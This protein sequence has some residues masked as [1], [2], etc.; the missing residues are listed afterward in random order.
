MRLPKVTTRWQQA[1]KETPFPFNRLP[2]ELKLLI[3]E[4]CG[5]DFF[6][7]DTSRLTV[8]RQW[9]QLALPV[10][11]YEMILTKCRFPWVWTPDHSALENSVIPLYHDPAFVPVAVDRIDKYTKV[12]TINIDQL[13]HRWA[14]QVGDGEFTGTTLAHRLAHL[15][16]SKPFEVAPFT[17]E[18]ATLHALDTLSLLRRG[19]IKVKDLAISMRLSWGVHRQYMAHLRSVMKTVITTPIE[20]ND[21]SWREFDDLTIDM[22]GLWRA[23][24]YWHADTQEVDK[25]PD[26]SLFAIPPLLSI[27]DNFNRSGIRNDHPDLPLL[28]YRDYHLCDAIRRR[29]RTVRRLYLR[30]GCVCE[31]IFRYQSWRDRCNLANQL[32]PDSETLHEAYIAGV[33]Q[34]RDGVNLSEP[35]ANREDLQPLPNL[36]Q[37]IINMVVPP[38]QNF[39]HPRVVHC[40]TQDAKLGLAARHRFADLALET[41]KREMVRFTKRLVDPD[42]VLLR[43]EGP[44]IYTANEFDALTGETRLIS[45]NNM[46]DKIR[47]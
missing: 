5:P 36:K 4:F 11:Y 30:L 47:S 35:G 9:Y 17:I 21:P 22:P 25:E 45:I 27:L 34:S 8:S 32:W 38:G 19:A 26:F 2:T 33:A 6:A 43:Y 15:R 42:C 40:C 31:E 24:D 37:L 39:Y 23:N 10:L 29:L 7:E 41:M 14:F 3:V 20:D 28:D 13:F 46:G 1:K 16:S 44:T 18:E 12:V